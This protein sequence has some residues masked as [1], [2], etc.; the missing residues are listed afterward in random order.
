MLSAFKQSV[1]SVI[2]NVSPAVISA[3]NGVS[4]V[5]N[6]LSSEV[7]DEFSQVMSPNH[8]DRASVVTPGNVSHP[9]ATPV[10][11][12]VN[13]PVMN[14]QP[15]DE[16]CLSQGYE[17]TVEVEADDREVRRN[18]RASAREAML[19]DDRQK[20]MSRRVK[21]FENG[22]RVV[23]RNLI[24]EFGSVEVTDACPV[25]PPAEQTACSTTE[26]DP[27]EADIQQVEGERAPPP[28]N[29]DEDTTAP[30]VDEATSELKKLT[31][32]LE[33]ANLRIAEF[34]AEK[35]YDEYEQHSS[36][37]WNDGADEGEGVGLLGSDDDH[38]G[39]ECYHIG[40]NDE[41]MALRCEAPPG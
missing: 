6:E 27:D 34:E 13:T 28:V 26:I 10:V 30:S 14:E 40:D 2:S 32:Q 37:F 17:A 29:I 19:I 23:T 11:V 21:R 8:V 4:K 41:D 1:S 39:A 9:V 7:R 25:Q 12:S 5:L 3:K 35:F 38:A 36:E 16:Q 31:K 15:S 22:G 33:E 24:E 18:A 20:A